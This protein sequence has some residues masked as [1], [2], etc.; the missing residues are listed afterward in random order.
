MAS[1]IRLGLARFSSHLS[2]SSAIALIKKLSARFGA[3]RGLRTT[4]L[5]PR[6]GS[7]TYCGGVPTRHTH[8]H[9]TSICKQDRFNV[10]IKSARTFKEPLDYARR[11]RHANIAHSVVVVQGRI[12]ASAAGF[13]ARVAPAA[14]DIAEPSLDI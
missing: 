3:T 6:G 8:S 12:V 4:T 14:K 10:L 1:F 2:A 7:Y 9:S 11:T 13:R 5:A